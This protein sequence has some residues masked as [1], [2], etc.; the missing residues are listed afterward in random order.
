MRRHLHSP[1]LGLGLCS[2]MQIF[3]KTPDGKTI[4]LEVEA[5]DTIDDVKA[6]IQEKTCIPAQY[7]ALKYDGTC[8][9]EWSVMDYDIFSGQVLELIAPTT[10]PETLSAGSSSVMQRA[11]DDL[12]APFTPDANDE[13]AA[14]RKR[15]V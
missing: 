11:N 1:I 9:S 3:V 14:K 15:E 5:R 7:Q 8:V 13:H 10:P 6:K 4:S 2:G 12:G